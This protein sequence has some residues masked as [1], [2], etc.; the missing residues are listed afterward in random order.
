[1]GFDDYF[2]IVWD[3]TNFAH[4]NNILT[5]PGRGSAAGSLVSYT[6]YITDIDPIK[7]DLIFER[8][9]NEERAQMPDI[10]LD[11]PDIKRDTIIEYLHQKYGQ[12]HMAQIITFGT[13]KTKQVL[14]DVARVFDL[15]T[16]EAVSNNSRFLELSATKFF[17]DWLLAYASF[18]VIPYSLGIALLHASAS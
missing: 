3:V 11:I 1:M 15:K 2:L 16:Y 14:R 8:F 12:Q 5:G 10:D 4:E 17:K 7:Y 9:L 6:L 18:K 13:L